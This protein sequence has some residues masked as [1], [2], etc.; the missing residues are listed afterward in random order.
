MTDRARTIRIGAL[1]GLIGGLII[2][3]YE[4][5]VWVNIQHLMPLSGLPANATG[6]VFGQD[7]KASL[8]WPIS[9]VI[10]TAIH[11]G[12]SC[13]WDVLFALIWP[14]FRKR[15]FEA[16]FV[17]LFYAVL[18]WIVMHLAIMSATPVHPNYGDPNVILGG[19]VS[20][21]FFT[22]PMALYIKRKMAGLG[23]A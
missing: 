23:P 15:G 18:A 1:G 20:H 22:V 4:I 13:A 3:I 10:G 7:V 8:G 6:L 5:V 11:F 12:F 21:A 16:T 14:W 2:W 17:A 19:F 9:A